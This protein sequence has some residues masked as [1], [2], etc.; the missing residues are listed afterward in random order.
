[1][2]V[3]SRLD[4][5]ISANSARFQ[6]EIQNVSTT[7]RR[8]AAQLQREQQ[9]QAQ[10]RLQIERQYASEH[11]RIEMALTDEV[12]RIR[13]AQFN[14]A[15]EQRYNAQ[16]RASAQQQVDLIAQQER[17]TTGFADKAKAAYGDIA[18][19]VGVAGAAIG[20]LVRNQ[21]EMTAELTKTAY[22]ANTTV[23]NIQ[24][25]VVAAKG[26]GIETDKLGD[27]FKDTQD[28]VGDFLTTGGGEMAD[29]FE[30]IAP[31]A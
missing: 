8:A 22:I 1:M 4:I 26:M 2:A 17:A 14:S 27:I 13:A 30:N 28:K 19:A 25:Y 12:E 18:I 11:R 10:S 21:I 15:D 20:A 3:L 29:F 23:E 6:Q 5:E 24:K 16:A 7:S 31:Q 9:Q